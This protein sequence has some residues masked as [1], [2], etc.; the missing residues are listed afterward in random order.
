M[1]GLVDIEAG[2][3]VL[4]FD[5]PYLFPGADLAEWLEKFT[6]WGGG[7]EGFGAKEI[8]VIHEVTEVRP[9]TYTAFH[10][11]RRYNPQPEI[12]RAPRTHVIQAFTSEAEAIA[13]RDKFHAIG[14]ETTE[15]IEA[16]ARR[17]VA[18]FAERTKASA[19]RK[20]HRCFP[21]IYRR[22]A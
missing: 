5:Q 3:W 9:K 2:K 17:R 20:I 15:A 18:K 19:L 6:I 21:H 8:F 11:S 12:V 13:A 14:V 16:E 7:W 1:S 22:C 4:A 10:R